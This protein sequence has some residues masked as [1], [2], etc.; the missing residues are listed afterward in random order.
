MKQVNLKKVKFRKTVSRNL[1]RKVAMN[2]KADACGSLQGQVVQEHD[3]SNSEI[4]QLH[5]QASVVTSQNKLRAHKT[6]KYQLG[7]LL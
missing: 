4:L 2:G 1:T 5:N 6:E 3:G 7:N